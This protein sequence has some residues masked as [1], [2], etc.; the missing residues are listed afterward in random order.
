MTHRIHGGLLPA[1]AM[2][3]TVASGLSS[4]SKPA[5][6]NAAQANATEENAGA[7]EAT[8]PAAPSNDQSTQN[9]KALL[10]KM[11]D[12]LAAQKAF[13][14]SYD[15]VFEVVSDQHQKF[16]I[17]TSGTVDMSRPDK[18]RAT[19]KSGFT[20]TETVFDGK[21]LTIYGKGKNA[22]VQA[23]V[24]GTVD[25]LIDQLRDRFHRQL[26][27]ADLLG[28]NV[29]DTLMT[30]VTDV[31][32]LGSGVVGGQECD[33]LAFR[34][35]DTDWQIWI[36]QGANPYPCRYVITSKGV[37]Q[38]PQF[39]MTIRDWKAGGAA[40][41]GFKPPAGATKLDAKDLETLKETSDLPE[42]YKI[43]AAK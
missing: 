9:A 36:A 22:Y 7:Q 19:R 14:L 35:K 37:D 26:P 11:S 40:D 32:D 23:E 21:T 41:F 25:N 8:E 34:A 4:C 15:S 3:L 18:I 27:G 10:K 5:E 17:A 29:Y 43:G 28:S 1:A 13:S 12:Y 20:D 24:P 6:Q 42:N 38:A 2:A 39:T 16:Q 33:H 30:D 31:K